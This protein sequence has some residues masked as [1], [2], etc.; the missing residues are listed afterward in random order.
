MIWHIGVT[1]LLILNEDYMWYETRYIE[2]SKYRGL[3]YSAPGVN[4]RRQRVITEFS[5]EGTWYPSM[6]LDTIT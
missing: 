5:Y 3:F 6:R 4:G 2:I 1:C